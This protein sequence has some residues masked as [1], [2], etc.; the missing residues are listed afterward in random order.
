MLVQT[1]KRHEAI[2]SNVDFNCKHPKSN[3]YVQRLACAKSQ[4]ITVTFTKQLSRFQ[5][6][7]KS[8]QGGYSNTTAI[9]N[10]FAK[11]LLGL[12]VP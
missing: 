1:R 11:V 5:E 4:V 7:E 10:D 9:K 12:F 2:T 6:E 8:I 3:V